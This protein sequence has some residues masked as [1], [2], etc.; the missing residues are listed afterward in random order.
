MQRKK[1][2]L[3]LGFIIVLTILVRLIHVTHSFWLDEAA[4]ALES[5]RPLR[6]Q[7]SLRDD[8]QPPLYH[9]VVHLLVGVAQSEWWLRLASLIP[10][11][12]SCAV[13]FLIAK[14]LGGWQRGLL[15][16]GL[17]A[18][19]PLHVFFSQ[20]LR[21]YALAC[22]FALLSWEWLF[23]VVEAQ[24]QRR[25]HQLLFCLW[26]IFGFYT[27]YL[28]PFVLISQ[29]LYV[30]IIAKKLRAWMLQS[31]VIIALAGS[32]W[33]PSFLG[34]LH[35]GQSLQQTLPGWSASVATPQLKAVVLIPIKFLIGQAEL[36]RIPA[37]GIGAGLIY[38][39]IG[40][41]L[42]R[43]VS[44]RTRARSL[45]FWILIPCIGAWVISFAV[46]VIQPKRLLFVVP[47]ICVL[48]ALL[49]KGKL[50]LTG[51]LLSLLVSFTSLAWYAVD[52]RFGREDWRG[53]L[54]QLSVMQAP[55]AIISAFPEPFAPLRWYAPE[56]TQLLNTR[57]LRLNDASE[58]VP[59]AEE[60]KSLQTVA[61]FDYLRDLSDPHHLL[62]TMLTQQG[63]TLKSIIDG[64]N[65]GF[66]RIYQRRY[67]Q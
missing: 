32:V 7:L 18:L 49:P 14:R 34:Q 61:V 43:N 22:F 8:F 11:V 45:L 37:F 60:V 66:V 27:M 4:Q 51:V 53:V 6:D 39:V 36:K 57:S 40:I 2:L 41:A 15:A 21:P 38:L 33:L 31:L 23:R 9:L 42:I 3:S 56:H 64:G 55:S 1:I 35:A 48:I 65:V 19:S 54:S 59:L 44:Y 10:G 62:E 26:S 58:L 24:Q 63:Y 28:Y 52:A 12:A 50:L 13:V 5:S 47:G 25:I 46:P 16:A 67:N 20:E 17:L 30:F 29:V